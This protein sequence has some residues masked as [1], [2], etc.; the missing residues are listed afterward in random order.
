MSTLLDFEKHVAQHDLK[1]VFNLGTQ[2]PAKVLASIQGAACKLFAPYQLS[3]ASLGGMMTARWDGSKA[4]GFVWNDKSTGSPASFSTARTPIDLNEMQVVLHTLPSGIEDALKT[5]FV[6]RKNDEGWHIGLGGNGIKSMLAQPF[7]GWPVIKGNQ[8]HYQ[9][10]F[11]S[12]L[13]DIAKYNPANPADSFF[14]TLATSHKWTKNPLN[15]LPDLTVPFHLVWPQYFPAWYRSTG[16]G[17]SQNRGIDRLLDEL[18]RI[19]SL[20]RNP[21]KL[22]DNYGEY[23]AAYRV[24]LLSYH[25][26]IYANPAKP[27]TVPHFDWLTEMLAEL[28]PQAET[29]EMLRSRKALVLYGVPGT[30]KTHAAQKFIAPAIANQNHIHIIQFHPAYSYADFLIGI[31]PQ[32]VGNGVTY[33]VVPG[34][35]YRIAAEAANTAVAAAASKTASATTTSPSMNN[36]DSNDAKKSTVTETLS[37]EKNGEHEDDSNGD[38]KNINYV[39]I[40]D[41]I[42]RADLAKVL[43]EAMFQLEYR[44]KNHTTSLPHRLNPGP[45]ISVFDNSTSISDPFSGGAKFY[46][47]DNLFIIGTMNHA[48]RSISGFDMALRRRFAWA[49][50][51]FSPSQL[52]EILN[53]NNISNLEPFVKRCWELNQWIEDG[54]PGPGQKSV[55]PFMPEHVLGHTFFAEICGILNGKNDICPHHL[56]RLWLYY[57]Q[58]QL[59]DALGYDASVYRKDLYTMRNNFTKNL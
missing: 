25:Y 41:E 59:E 40:I 56:E 31:R 45:L 2:T 9:S 47:P 58:P 46:L 14:K 38:A 33:P 52:R 18:A 44:G 7:P 27:V 35:L 16:G 13:D 57:L 55:I 12:A 4:R 43:G 21:I 42:N 30:S 17:Y 36:A 15:P 28:D 37:D 6:Y 29:I 24:L 54:S 5:L 22:S 49:R 51:D 8:T 1:V 11:N 20:N 19:L 50:H 23:S 48:D 32:S 26:F 10:I 53:P 34:I 3:L 39:L